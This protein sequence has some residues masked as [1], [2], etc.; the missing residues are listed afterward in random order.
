MIN[1]ILNVLIFNPLYIFTEFLNRKFSKVK[2]DYIWHAED[3]PWMKELEANHKVVLNEFNRY[4]A[5]LSRLPD[6]E[7]LRTSN[8]KANFGDGRWGMLYLRI[9]NQKN[10]LLSTHFPETV[11]LLETHV[12]ELFS[13]RF[14][15][16]GGNR[17]EITPHRDGHNQC[18]I[19]HLP[20]VVPEGEC[21]ITINGVR[22]PW[23]EG[24]CF[25]FDASALH[26]V[27]KESDEER[28]VVLI[29]T[30]R[31]VPKWV[32]ALSRFVFNYQVKNAP[33]KEI[34]ELHDKALNDARL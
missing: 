30:F 15:L 3:M 25:A 9:N 2:S 27:T 20:L 28:L 26:S 17:K 24:K 5:S 23:E 29:D 31:P 10:D 1:I 6:L 4:R 21:S 7:D 18:I 12:P 13:I 8:N 32:R 11:K 34:F 16:L 22:Q 14:S 19:C 33:V